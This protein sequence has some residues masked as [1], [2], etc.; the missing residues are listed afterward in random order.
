MRENAGS[1]TRQAQFISSTH[2]Q[3]HIQ[4]MLFAD[5][6]EVQEFS[7]RS[8]LHTSLKLKMKFTVGWLASPRVGVQHVTPDRCDISSL[9]R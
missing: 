4:V 7:T 3:V 1:C 5:Q 8:V 6:L 9:R 2:V